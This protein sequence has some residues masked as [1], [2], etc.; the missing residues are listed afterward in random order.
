MTFFVDLMFLKKEGGYEK[1]SILLG[2]EDISFKLIINMNSVM[3]W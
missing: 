1:L 2:F 3:K